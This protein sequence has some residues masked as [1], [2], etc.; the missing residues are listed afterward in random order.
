MLFVVEAKYAAVSA[1]VEADR[2]SAHRALNNERRDINQHFP[3]QYVQPRIDTHA[4]ELTPSVGS[5]TG[6]NS[7]TYV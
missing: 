5:C 3:L 1:Q 4:H 7:G 2:L 6:T